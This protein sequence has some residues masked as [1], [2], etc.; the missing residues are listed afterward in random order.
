MAEYTPGRGAPTGA[1][2]REAR[3]AAVLARWPVLAEP[4]AQDMERRRVDASEPARVSPAARTG[5]NAVEL[6]ITPLQA[7][8]R[9]LGLPDDHGVDEVQRRREDASGG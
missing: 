6:G 4:W 5:A 9:A 1:A 8:N 7:I 3:W 2:G